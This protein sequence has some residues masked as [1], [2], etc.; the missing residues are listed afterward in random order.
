MVV[1]MLDMAAAQGSSEEED[2][3]LGGVIG[4]VVAAHY[5]DSECEGEAELESVG[6]GQMQELDGDVLRPLSV[7]V[8]DGHDIVAESG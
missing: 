4:R 5:N 3:N 8:I 1:G 2:V 7:D 6:K